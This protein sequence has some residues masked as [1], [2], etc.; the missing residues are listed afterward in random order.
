MLKINDIVYMDKTYLLD[1]SYNDAD[2]LK[3][4][5]DYIRLE[6]YIIGLNKFYEAIRVDP[7][8]GFDNYNKDIIQLCEA[9]LDDNI[10]KLVSSSRIIYYGYYSMSKDDIVCIHDL[11]LKFQEGELYGTYLAINKFVIKACHNK[12]IHTEKVVIFNEDKVGYI[13]E[14]PMIAMLRYY[15][16][17]MV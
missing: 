14:N 5:D 1:A 16:K 3:R 6:D 2:F 15:I 4:C 9:D 13:L 12:G 10:R 7:G 8:Y 17:D 11:M